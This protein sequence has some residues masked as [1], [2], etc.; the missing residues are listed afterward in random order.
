MNPRAAL[1]IGIIA[2]VALA[3]IIGF[4]YWLVTRN[5]GVRRKEYEAMRRERNLAQEALDQIEDHVVALSDLDHPLAAAI[6][7]VLRE[8]EINRREIAR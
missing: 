5:A 4:G 7:P 8:H 1:L 3:L 2:L 6:R